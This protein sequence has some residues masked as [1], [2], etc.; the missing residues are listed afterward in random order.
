MCER[1]SSGR[2]PELSQSILSG[3]VNLSSII[4][5]LRCDFVKMN[6]EI[7]L[8]PSPKFG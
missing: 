4:E 6:T 3:F 8:L 1:Q 7:I 5:R 2:F